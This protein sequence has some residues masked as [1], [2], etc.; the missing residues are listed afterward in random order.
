MVQFVPRISAYAFRQKASVLIV[1]LQ[2]VLKCVLILKFV[3]KHSQKYSMVQ[4][5]PLISGTNGIVCKCAKTW[6]FGNV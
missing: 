3:L 5:V 1:T 4:F 6:T 2:F